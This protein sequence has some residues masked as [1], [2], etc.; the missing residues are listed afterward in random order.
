MKTQR[1]RNYEF[2]QRCIIPLGKP[3]EQKLNAIQGSGFT[4]PQKPAI[5]FIAGSWTR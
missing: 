4:T 5:Q 1:Q 2:W 3:Q